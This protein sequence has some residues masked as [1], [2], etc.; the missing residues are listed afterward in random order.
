MASLDGAVVESAVP[1]TE[2]LLESLAAA[3]GVLADLFPADHGA[4]A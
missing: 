4:V 1:F 2:G 3:G